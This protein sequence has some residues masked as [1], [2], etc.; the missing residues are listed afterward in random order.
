MRRSLVAFL[1]SSAACGHSMAGDKSAYTLFN[2]V[3]EAEMRGFDTDRPDKTNSAITVDAGHFQLEMDLGN[4]ARSG[5]GAGKEES[6]LW[7]NTNLRIGLMSD[8]DLQLMVPFIQDDGAKR[9]VGD[10]A[11][12]LK[13]NIWG[14]DGGESAAGF[15]MIFSAPTGAHGLSAE[16]VQASF[17]AIYQRSFGD[18]GVGYNAGV[19]AVANDDGGTHHAEIINTISI[20]HGLVGPLTG[21]VEFFT[22]VPTAHSGEWVGTVDAGVL[23]L[24]AKNFQIDTGI[25]VGV[26]RA[27]D[28]LQVFLGFSWRL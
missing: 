8:I 25:N 23:W 20:S 27:A 21:Y 3:P 1:L 24:L 22:S 7:G 19:V 12:A 11:V 6:W 26:T 4:Y 18:L 28:D 5:H 9:G 17:L 14:N 10:M 15:E 16:T 2:P 13:A